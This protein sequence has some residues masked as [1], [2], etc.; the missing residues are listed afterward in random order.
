MGFLALLAVVVVACLAAPVYASVVAGTG[1]VETH[2][3]DTVRLGG[4]DVDVVALDGTPLDPTWRTTY[5][6]GADPIGRDVAVRL[7]YGARNSLG[8]AALA[9]LISI[10]LGSI[11]GLLAGYLGGRVDASVMRV[12][13]VIWSFPVLL[14]GIAIGTTLAVRDGNIGP[15]DPRES[16][17]VITALL[18]GVVST[19][20]AARPVRARVRSLR[21]EPFVD[22]AV[23]GGAGTWHVVVRE[24]LPNLSFTLVALFTVLFA[25]GVLLE[26]A[27]SFL[28]A[29]VRPPDA[30]LGTMVREGL[31]HFGQSPHLLIVPSVALTVAVLAVNLAGDAVRRALDPHEAGPRP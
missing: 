29:G 18:I 24:V 27:L 11:A 9:A 19:P 3:T 20:Y 28:G 25:N 6:L 13:D 12:L 30:S 17:K 8:I 16:S 23:L 31:A 2:L 10:T 4:R 22:A 5:L 15:I 1:P 7:L 14:A 26:S 21:G